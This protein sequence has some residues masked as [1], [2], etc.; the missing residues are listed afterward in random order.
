MASLAQAAS[1]SQFSTVFGSLPNAHP[2]CLSMER[3]SMTWSPDWS[4]VVTPGLR[5][6]PDVRVL[7]VGA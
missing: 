1:P 6:S 5:Q 4:T 7:G 3:I 2:I